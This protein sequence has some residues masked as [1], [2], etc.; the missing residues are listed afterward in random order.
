[1][2]VIEI[3]AIWCSSCLIMKKVW[4]N[5]KQNFEN[6]EWIEY[7]L[8]FDSEVKSY[9]VGATLPVLIFEKEGMETS[10]L[11]G[12]KTMEEVFKWLE[13]NISA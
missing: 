9:Q 11:V 8:D 3:S 13:E 4:K 5:A 6:L 1:M 10:R 2:K 7:D 12:E